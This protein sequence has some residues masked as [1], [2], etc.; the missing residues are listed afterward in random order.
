MPLG[1]RFS[2]SFRHHVTARCMILSCR[3][4]KTRS[5]VNPHSQGWSGVWSFLPGVVDSLE[6]QPRTRDCDQRDTQI[7]WVCTGKICEPDL[8]V[9]IN[10]SFLQGRLPP[11]GTAPRRGEPRQTSRQGGHRKRCAVGGRLLV[12]VEKRLAPTKLTVS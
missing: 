9:R 1:A 8:T 5:P 11:A 4:Q 6:V 10:Q 12:S 2:I 3:V 7:G